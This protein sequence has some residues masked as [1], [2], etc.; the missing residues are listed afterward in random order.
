MASRAVREVQALNIVTQELPNNLGVQKLNYT[1]IESLEDLDRIEANESWVLSQ[2][3]VCKSDQLV[4]RRAKSGLITVNS[5][6]NEVKEFVKKFINK[7]FTVGGTTGKLKT[8][9]VTPFIPHKQDEESYICMY[10]GRDEDCILFYHAGGIDIGNVEDKAELIKIPTTGSTKEQT[11]S[12]E[13]ALRLLKN[14]SPSKKERVAKVVQGLY[15]MYKEQYFTYLEVNPL[16]ITDEKIYILDLA[17]KVDSAADY[18]F[19]SGR[20]YIKYIRYENI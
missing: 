2:K 18:L 14:L 16:V 10:S 11:V 12:T 20:K 15:E 1:S 3:L 17:A 7:D 4:K 9:I 5:N 19:P 6:W 13:A 8:F